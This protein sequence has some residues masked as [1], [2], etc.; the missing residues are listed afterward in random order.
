M[1]RIIQ[2]GIVIIICFSCLSSRGQTSVFNWDVDNPHYI[3]PADAA[4]FNIGYFDI[5]GLTPHIATGI[6]VG[7]FSILTASSGIGGGDALFAASAFDP[8]GGPANNWVIFGPIST[9]TNVS[10]VIS[11]EHVFPA[12]PSRDG[13]EVLVSNVGP[14]P[15]DFNTATQIANY[16]DNDPNTNG[17]NSWTQQS[18]T[19]PQSFAGGQI[20]IAFHHFA[21]D[22]FQM[23]IDDIDVAQTSIAST[24]SSFTVNQCNN[25]T[26]PS[27]DETYTT[28]GV[29]MDTIPN[30]AGGDS[31]MTITANILQPSTG[32]DIQTSCGAF[33]WI[34]G[35]TY[36]SSNNTATH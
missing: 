14:T 18:A 16:S 30:T 27:G 6:P 20:Y 10:S 17:H 34:D 12:N 5:D 3:Q 4:S 1:K 29:Y 35:N 23:G 9:P 19:I 22:Q 7:S 13:Y 15:G 33:T 36:S 11:W 31:I 26:V 28:S 2:I 32:T 8:S 24:S 21:N 25:Y